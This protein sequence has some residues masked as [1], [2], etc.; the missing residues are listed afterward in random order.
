MTVAITGANG[1]LGQRLIGQLG[2][3]GVRAIVRSDRARTQVQDVAPGV[4]VRVVDYGDATGLAEAL[5]GCRQVVHLVGI[6]KESAANPF[7]KAHEAACKALVE[8]A[9]KAGLDGIVHLSVLG[10]HPDS[11]NACL[12]S[13]GRADEILVSGEVSARVIRVPMV[14]GEGDYASHALARQ[15]RSR[16]A[17]TFRAS[18]LEQPIYA[19]DVADAL[20][21]SLEDGFS[22]G[23]V[24]LAGPESLPRRALITRAGRLLGQ[25]PTVISLPIGLGLA[26]AGILELGAN[27]PITRAMLGVLDHDDEV[28]VAPACEILRLELTSLDETIRRVAN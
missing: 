16:V 8:A 28:D 20:L 14:L 23:V 9:A 25:S 2:T 10:S 21:H 7:E 4:D 11:A 17:V 13:R 12:A 27:P 22:S 15:G 3:T 1:H 19:G 26:I 18:S 5:A 6:I 24:E